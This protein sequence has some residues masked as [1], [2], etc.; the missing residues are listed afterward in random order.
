MRRTFLKLIAAATFALATPAIAQDA[1][2]VMVIE[3]DGEASGTVEIELL[4]D[5][6][7][8]HV[9]RLKEL[10]RAGAYN[11]VAFHRVIPGFM[12]QTGDVQ[13]GKRE[14]IGEGKAG[15]GG[16]DLPNVPAEFTDEPFLTGIVGMAR[17]QNPDSANSQFFIMVADGEF[18]NNQYTV[19]GRVLTGMDVV[20][21]IK[22][23]AGQNGAVTDP[24]YMTSVTIKGDQ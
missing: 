1:A 18:L 9:E 11:D 3:I 2:N 23:G 4:P 6:A 14:M 7:P 15:F 10:A 13:F 19:V 21:S 20:Q 24:D 12:A 22:L 5:L 16:S 17:S 8:Q